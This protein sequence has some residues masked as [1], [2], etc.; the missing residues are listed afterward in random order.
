MTYEL[1]EGGLTSIKAWTTGVHI[2]ESAKKQLRET[3]SLPIVGPHIAVMPDV[4]WGMGSTVGSVVPTR[5]AIVPACVGVDLGCGMSAIPT[6]LTSYDLGDDANAIFGALEESIP[7]GR[8]DDG[9]PNDRGAWSTIPDDVASRWAKLSAS[10][11]SLNI[12]RA[13]ERAPRQLG[14]LGTGNHFVE[15][16][17]DET[18]HVWLMLHSGSR[19]VGNAIG[20]HYIALAKKR[21]ETERIKLPNSDLAWLPE[22]TPE[23]DAYIGA[24]SWAQEYANQNRKAMMRA[25]CDVMERLFG[26]SQ[27]AVIGPEAVNCHHNYV[28]RETHFGEDL[29]ITRKGA[30]SARRG[31]LGIIPGS[32]GAK[33][34]IVRGKGNADSSHSCSHGA[35]RVMSRGTAKKAITLEQHAAD[36]AG[37]ACRKDVDVLDE[38]PRAYK[39]IDSVMSAQ[40]DLVEIVNILKAVVCVKG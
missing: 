30:V 10:F 25:A 13:A 22:G 15:V 32:M 7:H 34:F 16:C 28:S 9:G 2:E 12:G 31:E 29:L 4:H 23:F 18:D 11:E 20:Q 14:T 39:D 35:G 1:I 27:F 26:Q 21:C 19:G 36:T 33:G 17:L 24:V 5:G 38:S 3:A 8:T 37:V 40:S 6:T